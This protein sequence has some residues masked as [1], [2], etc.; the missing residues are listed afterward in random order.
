MRFFLTLRFSVPYLPTNRE[1]IAREDTDPPTKNAAAAENLGYVAYTAASTRN[2][3]A[4]H[5]R[6]MLM[7]L[8]SGRVS[9]Y[10]TSV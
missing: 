1:S 9:I 7:P 4:H 5:S 10:T 6:A 2:P 3:Q 8:R